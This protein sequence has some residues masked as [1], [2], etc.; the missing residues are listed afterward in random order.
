MSSEKDVNIE[1]ALFMLEHM[2]VDDLIEFWL[3]FG[4]CRWGPAPEKVH[5]WWEGLPNISVI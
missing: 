1:R 5:P 2:N 4:P 3:G